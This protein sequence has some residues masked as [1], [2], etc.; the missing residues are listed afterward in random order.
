M[1]FLL[2]KNQTPDRG[3]DGYGEQRKQRGDQ[4]D[5]S[6]FDIV[7]AEFSADDESVN[8]GRASCGDQER[9]LHIEVDKGYKPQKNHAG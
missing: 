6:A 1:L 4:Y 3:Q 8:S 2:L 5:A 9:H 7:V